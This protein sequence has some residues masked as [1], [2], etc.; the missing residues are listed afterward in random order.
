MSV[1]EKLTDEEKDLLAI[2]TDTSGV[3]QAEF[4]WYAADH[5]E[6][7]FRPWPFQEKWWRDESPLILDQCSR[8]CG[9]ALD[10]LT[11]VPTPT[12]WT[13]MGDLRVGD[14]VFGEDG[15][16]TRVAE[17]FDVMHGRTCYEIEFD[18]GSTIVADEDHQWSTWDRKSVKSYARRGLG[19]PEIRTTKQIKDGVD[20]GIAYTVGPAPRLMQPFRSSRKAVRIEGIKSGTRISRR[21]IVSVSQVPSRPVRC[22]AVDNDSH[23]FLAGRG[24]IPTHN[25]LSIQVKACAFPILFPA[26]EMVITAPE[27]NHLDAV[28]DLIET[29]L[30]GTRFYRELLT[31]NANNGITHRPFLVKFRNAARIMGRIPQKDGSGVKGSMESGTLILTRDRSLQRVEDV[32][33]G[34]YVWSHLGRWTKVLDTYGFIQEGGYLANCQASFP[35]V[36]SVDHRWF[37]RSDES[38]MPGKTKRELGDDGWHWADSMPEAKWMNGVNSYMAVPNNFGDSLPIPEPDFSRTRTVFELN[39]D[40]WWMVGRYVADGCAD[41]HS[42]SLCVHPKDQEP[43]LAHARRC[44]MKVR[45]QTRDHSSADM[46]LTGNTGYVKWLREHFGHHSHHKEIP[47]WL[48]TAPEN[49]RQA[50]FDGY[51]S[52][53]GCEYQHGNQIRINGGSASKKLTMGLGL[54]G[55]TLGLTIGLGVTEIKVTQICGT[56]LKAPAQPRYDYRFNKK[57][58]AIHD[59]DF[60]YYKMKSLEYVEGEFEYFGLV[61]EDY[62]YL[63]EGLI[64]HNTHPIRLEMDEAQNYPG[65][66]WSEVIETLKRGH[67]GRAWR[68]HGVSRGIRDKFYEFSQPDSD[69]KV[70]QITAMSRPTWTDEERQEKIKMYGSVDHPDYR[71]NVLGSHGD[72]QNPL[73]VL[74]RLAKCFDMDPLSDHNQFEYFYTKIGAE[75]IED[76]EG[77]I[78]NIAANV[79]AAHSAYKVVWAGMDVGYVRDPSE[80]LIF[81]ESNAVKKTD[82]SLLKLIARFHLDRVPNPQQ[83]ALVKWI[84]EYYNIAGFST[85]KMQPVSE[86]VLT[87]DGWVKIGDIRVGDS[88][89]GSDGKPTEVTGVYPQKDKRVMRV[90]LDDGS[91][92]RCGPEHLWTVTNTNKALKENLVTTTAED[93]AVSMKGKYRWQVPLLSSPVEYPDQ[94]PLPIDPYALGLLIGDGNLRKSSIRFSSAD[95]E[96]I[97]SLRRVLPGQ[98]VEHIPSSKYDYAITSSA[99]IKKNKNGTFAS[100]NLLLNELRKLGLAGSFSH[101]K[102]IPDIY[103]SSSPSER[104]ALIQGLMDSDGYAHTGVGAGLRTA[105]H[106]LAGDMRSV[107]ESLGGYTRLKVHATYIKD[108][109]YRDANRLTVVLPDGIP[110]FRLKRKLESFTERKVSPRR[111]ISKIEMEDQEEESVCIRVAAEDSLYVTRSHILTHNTGAGLPLFQDLQAMLEPKDLFKIKGY[112]FSE[113]IITGFDESIDL[114]EF[115]GDKIADAA[116]KKNV[117]DYSTDLLRLY[118][119]QRRLVMPSDEEVLKEFQGQTWRAITP[120]STG[121]SRTYSKGV[122]HALDAARMAVLGHAQHEI[123]AFLRN[124]RKTPKQEPV[125]DLFYT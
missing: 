22:I 76:N 7:C 10:V 24:M 4:L 36:V 29:R 48:L 69:W 80:I 93:L 3:D 84:I 68:A 121:Q 32:V 17:A 43:V 111:Y 16:Q 106:R 23:L 112:G 82:P 49:V 14:T 103:M 27:G 57:G 110:P 104:I 85:D 50:F 102:F 99:G 15:E 66:G 81:A 21:R 116:L 123:E 60:S 34:D 1:L 25:S 109:R 97:E 35:V 40:F 62:S 75:Q 118:V 122:F 96:I 26:Q 108:H 30:R 52:G 6:G 113:K 18:D 54:L 51:I 98:D 47:T 53:D 101:N 58:I 74:R 114:E 117:L 59:K 72:T 61:T 64:S 13:T 44:G 105:S 92:T 78:L 41:D 12:G 8:A 55:S 70:F 91:W 100:Y 77:D 56:E 79:P 11:P 9:K 120:T 42:I 33:I 124:E 5:R 95:D 2:L 125:Y 45:I 119:D 88:V 39:D 87:P 38:K 73:F 83:A 37:A 89:V 65:P 63:S 90:T 86:P 67:A 71:R 20:A 19:S 107:I 115:D 94:G 46:L 28:T 31:H